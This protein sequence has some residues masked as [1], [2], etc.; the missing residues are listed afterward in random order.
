MKKKNQTKAKHGKKISRS[1]Q[2]GSLLELSE[3]FG[4]YL[5]ALEVVSSK[6]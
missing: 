1:N 3:Y 6:D 4:S 2:K 5:S